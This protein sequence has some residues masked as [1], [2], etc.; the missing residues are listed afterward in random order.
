MSKS[1]GAV[2]FVVS[3]A[4]LSVQAS[5]Q[6]AVSSNDRKMV[7]DNGVPKVVAGPKPDTATVIDLGVTPP[8]VLAEIDVPGSVVGPPLSVAVARDGSVAYVASAMKIDAKDPTKQE[9]DDKIAIIDLKASP[10]KVVGQI[11]AGKAPSGMSITP[12]GKLL[13]VANRNEGSVSMYALNGQE[14]REL[15]KLTI[16]K[17]TSS[18]SHVAVTPDG[19]TALVSMYGDNTVK[20]LKIDG[21]K[22]E[23]TK[24]EISVGTRPYPVVVHPGGKMALVANVG[25]G[26]GDV[27]TLTVIDLSK[28]PARAV[29]WVDLGYETP[30]GMMLSPDGKWC[31]VVLHNGTGRPKDSPFFHT[32]GRLVVYRVDGMRLTKAAEAPIGRWS[33]GIAFSRDG[34][35]IVVQN[36]VEENAMVFRWDGAKLVDTGKPIKLGGG[37]AAIRTAGGL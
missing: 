21:E 23:D 29:G 36:M 20:V 22:L 10:P 35:T 18:P 3:L 24:R 8:K 1:A 19:K 7:L 9:A 34:R 6:I 37:G 26:T 33:Q 28:N 16:G 31:G 25:R 27:D 14:A 15:T 11:Q 4:C 12:D 32:T 5:A 2:A 13:L 30:E 17:D